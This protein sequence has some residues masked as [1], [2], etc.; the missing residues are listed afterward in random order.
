MNEKVD[1]DG[2]RPAPPGYFETMSWKGARWKASK[3]ARWLPE[4]SVGVAIGKF[5]RERY[6]LI[7]SPNNLKGRERGEDTVQAAYSG[8]MMRFYDI[9]KERITVVQLPWMSEPKVYL[10]TER[11]RKTYEPP[12]RDC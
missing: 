5:N 6:K 4:D 2:S 10:E 1:T 8:L 9:G 12:A 3:A 7:Y 11:N